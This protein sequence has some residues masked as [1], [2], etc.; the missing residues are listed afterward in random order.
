[1]IPTPSLYGGWYLVQ[2]SGEIQLWQSGFGNWWS[3]C[4]AGTD[5]V[6]HRVASG[7]VARRRFELWRLASTEIEHGRA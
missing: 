3:V 2:Q 6:D 7:I 4:R 5:P 1:M